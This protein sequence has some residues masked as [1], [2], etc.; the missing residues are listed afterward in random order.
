MTMTAPTATPTAINAPVPTRP[1]RSVLGPTPTYTEAL[2]VLANSKMLRPLLKG[3][4]RVCDAVRLGCNLLARDE[5]AV[6]LP[7]QESVHL[8]FIKRTALVTVVAAYKVLVASRFAI[9]AAPA[10]NI[11]GRAPWAAT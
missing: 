3:C 1:K 10:A 5:E 8:T 7:D 4:S 6:E 2:T 11:A 9:G